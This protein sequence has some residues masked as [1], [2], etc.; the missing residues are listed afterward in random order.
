MTTVARRPRR[1]P[2]RDLREQAERVGIHPEIAAIT[3]HDDLAAIIRF[4]PAL[5]IV[6]DADQ[7]CPDERASTLTFL[8]SLKGEPTFIQPIS[9]GAHEY[10]PHDEYTGGDAA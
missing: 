1:I 7:E 8:A 3:P 5:R 10:T 2:H 9:L 6:P 4:A